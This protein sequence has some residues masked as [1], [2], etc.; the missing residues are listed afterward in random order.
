M[1]KLKILSNREVKLLK[2]EYDKP[3]YAR[4]VAYAI[5]CKIE[6]VLENIK[7]ALANERCVNKPIVL[8]LFDMLRLGLKT[9][10]HSDLAD[11]VDGLKTEFEKRTLR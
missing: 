1:K 5:R 6:C 8:H 11:R 9:L 10:G 4:N 3:Q 2:G 7:P